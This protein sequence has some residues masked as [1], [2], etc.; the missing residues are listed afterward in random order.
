MTQTYIKFHPTLPVDNERT[1]VTTEEGEQILQKHFTKNP[2]F[3]LKTF[4]KKQKHK[5][6]ILKEIAARFDSHRQYTEK[7]VNTILEGI[8]PDYVTIRRY[9]IDYCFFDRKPD[10]SAYWLT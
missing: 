10:G 2:V 7:E 4:P 6:V 3:R 8:Y 5:L 9:L 1:I